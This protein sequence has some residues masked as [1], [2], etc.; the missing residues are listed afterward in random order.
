MH[1]EELCG[2]QAQGTLIIP[3]IVLRITTIFIINNPC[4]KRMNS[5]PVSKVLMQTQSMNEEDVLLI[6]DDVEP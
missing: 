6:S 5:P 1:L 3:K 4:S 2:F